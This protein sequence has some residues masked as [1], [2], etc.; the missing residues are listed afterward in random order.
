MKCKIV[1]CEKE[2]D[3]IDLFVRSVSHRYRSHLLDHVVHGT[4]TDDNGQS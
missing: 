3:L 1:N 4:L 2:Y